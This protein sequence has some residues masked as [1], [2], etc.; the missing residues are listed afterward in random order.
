V[1][2]LGE[3]SVVYG[4]PAIAVPV[5]DVQACVEVEPFPHPGVT[6]RATD[7]GSRLDL[8]RAPEDE[9]LCLTVR[10]TL[11]HLNVDARDLQLCLTIRSTIPV[12]SGLGSGAAVATALVRALCAHLDRSLDAETISALVYQTE[13]VF[14]GTPSGIDNTVVVFEQAVYYVKGQ[15]IKRLA[16]PRP[17]WLVIADSGLPSL[18][19][20]SVADVRAAW[21]R[22][23]AGYAA[24][25]DEIAAIVVQAQEALEGGEVALLGPLMNANQRLLR[26]LDV[27][28]PEL[29]TLIEAAL[30]SGA[31]GAKLSGGG[32]GGNVIALVERERAE[33]VRRALLA[34]GAKNVIVTRVG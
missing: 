31:S 17:F 34:A 10:N 25:F 22:D 18:T 20:E 2:L 26:R 3:H 8:A 1:I 21:R 33:R 29:E 5:V 4:R 19:K 12:A 28:G 15:P 7:I 23:T 16:V 6:I 9:P 11:S 14:H 13:K 27:S 32:R 24:A 30:R